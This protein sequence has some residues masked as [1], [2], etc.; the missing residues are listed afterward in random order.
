MD[1]NVNEINRVSSN[2]IFKGDLYSQNDIRIDGII[3][4]TVCS[5]GKVVVG[6][7]A[8]IK[9]DIVASYIDIWGN[10]EGTLYSGDTLSLKAT[11]KVAGDLNFSRLQIEIGADFV[12]ACKKLSADEYATQLNKC[13]LADPRL[14][15]IAENE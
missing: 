7:K 6:E 2:S 1:T 14:T 12:G 9:G 5:E 4:G 13:R 3:F 8:F 11:A 15:Q 10:V